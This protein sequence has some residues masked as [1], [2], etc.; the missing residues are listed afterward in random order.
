MVLENIYI[1]MVKFTKDSYIKVKD[2]VTENITTLMIWYIKDPGFKM[3]ER[4]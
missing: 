2:T 4:D 1:K 3:K